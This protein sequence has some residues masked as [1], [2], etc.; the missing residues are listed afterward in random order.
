[1]KNSMLAK[2][3]IPIFILITLCFVNCSSTPTAGQEKEL[4]YIAGYTNN[5]L[6]YW[7]NEERTSLQ[8]YSDENYSRVGSIFILK[9][10]IYIS[11]YSGKDIKVEPFYWKNNNK[12]Y[13]VV[14]KEYG[15]SARGIFVDSSDIYVVGKEKGYGPVYWKNNKIIKLPIDDWGNANSI[16]VSEKDVYIAGY[17][18]YYTEKY[19]LIYT[20][21]YW[22]NDQRID[23]TK[24]LYNY[25]GMAYSIFVLNDDVYVSGVVSDKYYD[26]PC[27]WKNGIRTDLPNPSKRS[28]TFGIVTNNNSVYVVGYTE[29]D[30][31]IIPCYWKDSQ[32]VV[33]SN[34]NG[35]MAL[36]I[37]LY[38]DSVYISGYIKNE[39]NIEIPCY[40]KN[41]QRI[42]VGTNGR[43]ESIFVT[44]VGNK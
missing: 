27:Y 40:W 3:L 22:K 41:G 16:F 9:N 20:P 19:N 24:P 43:C 2:Q 10:D 32:K 12:Q 4:V 15:A 28:C 30:G 11:G 39:K 33:L 44:A 37:S 7:K 18:E 21:C 17:N 35:G 8:E 13:L 5:T 42:D 26:I 25:E 38:K 31:I 14:D 1:M 29:E 36:S 6:C 34:I 23:L